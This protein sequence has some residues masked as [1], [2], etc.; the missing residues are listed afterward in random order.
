MNGSQWL[1]VGAEVTIKDDQPRYGVQKD[2]MTSAPKEPSWVGKQRCILW[3]TLGIQVFL[4]HILS[5]T[6]EKNV[7]I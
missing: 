4:T 2:R 7:N 6:A 5:T 1:G 3:S